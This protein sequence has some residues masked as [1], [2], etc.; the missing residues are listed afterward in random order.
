[1]VFPDQIF[2]LSYFPGPK[3]TAWSVFTMPELG[4]DVTIQHAVTCGGYIFIRDTIDRIWVYGGTDGNAY[5][6]CGVEVRLPYLDGKKPGHKKV[7][8]AVDATVSFSKPPYSSTNLQTG[9]WRIAVSF[10]P[11]DPDQEDTLATISKPTWNIGASELQGYD[12]HF[13]LRF[14]NTDDKPVTLS[15][16]AVHYEMADA[17]A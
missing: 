14:Y 4:V 5:N 8:Q 17:E 3:V 2:V 10:D 6:A 9:E 1:M 13:S 12:S 16:C 11:T 15:N 7:F